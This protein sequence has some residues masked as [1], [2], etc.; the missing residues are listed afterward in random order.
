MRYGAGA[1]RCR[2]GAVW[3][4]A[5]RCRHGAVRCGAVRCGTIR[6]FAVQV[7]YGAV[8]CRHDEGSGQQD[9]DRGVE[10]ISDLIEAESRLDDD[11]GS[12]RTQDNSITGQVQQ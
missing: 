7:R 5:V 10:I 1:V 2:C 9:Q 3:C 11:R 4:F 6:C 12:G 8:R